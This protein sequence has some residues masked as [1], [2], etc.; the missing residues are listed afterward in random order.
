MERS[1]PCRRT[2]DILES[3]PSDKIPRSLRT[4]PIAKPMITRFWTKYMLNID[5][6]KHMF[7]IDLD[8]QGLEKGVG[9]H[10]RPLS[11]RSASHG[12]PDKNT[13]PLEERSERITALGRPLWGSQ[14]M[15]EKQPGQF[16]AV[17][18]ACEVCQPEDWEDSGTSLTPALDVALV[19]LRMS[20]QTPHGPQNSHRSD[21]TPLGISWYSYL[22][23]WLIFKLYF[24]LP[25]VAI[26][27][28]FKRRS[29]WWSCHTTIPPI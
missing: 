10:A 19:A 5:L 9:V 15:V 28:S 17:G 3:K 12:Y 14:T 13:G 1:L 4:K 23:R 25:D 21:M 22:I 16:P 6:K 24:V 8:P 29:T 18:H 27:S 7:I 26:A 20:P 2:W 11:A